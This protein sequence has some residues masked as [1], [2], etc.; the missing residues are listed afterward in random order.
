MQR[1]GFL[2]ALLGLAVSAV[3]AVLPKA[4]EPRRLVAGRLISGKVPS[5][6]RVHDYRPTP[7]TYR[8]HSLEVAQAVAVPN[9]K[10]ANG[11]LLWTIEVYAKA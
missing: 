11:N 4:D 2:G 9:T 7:V 5:R 1:R 3:A 10:D 6:V 8:G